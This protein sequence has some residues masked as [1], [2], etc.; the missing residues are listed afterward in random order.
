MDRTLVYL[1]RAACLTADGDAEQG[2][3]VATQAMLDLPASHRT[4]LVLLRARWL[5]ASIP[6]RLR[7]LS[8]FHDFHD[9]LRLPAM[10]AS[11][12]LEP[13]RDEEGDR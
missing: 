7:P 1:D 13:G 9:T 2:L 4:G 8:A 10:V 3:T 11:T 12:S 6:G 5:E